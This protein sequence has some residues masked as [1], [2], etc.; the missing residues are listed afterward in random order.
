MKS[1]TEHIGFE[2]PSRRVFEN[3]S[4]TVEDLVRKS[5]VRERLCLVNAMHIIKSTCG[6]ISSPG[7]F[8]VRQRSY[9][10]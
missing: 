1:L 9:I 10:I 6:F 7:T 2:I 8:P 3:I 5:G 4:A